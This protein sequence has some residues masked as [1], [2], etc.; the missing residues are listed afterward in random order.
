VV[1]LGSVAF[2]L[3]LGLLYRSHAIAKFDGRLPVKLV[4]DRGAAVTQIMSV[5]TTTGDLIPS[6]AIAGV[7]ALV[8]YQ[9]TRLWQ[10]WLLPLDIL[11]QIAIQ[12]AVINT[13][14]DYSVARVWPGITIG[15]TDGGVPSGSMARLLSVF[16]LTA[17]LWRPHNARIARRFTEIGLVVVLIELVTRMYLGRHFAGDIVAGL[18]L[19][20]TLT[21]AFGWVFTVLQRRTV[22]VVEDLAEGRHAQIR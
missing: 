9:R 13:M 17:I 20:V 12:A 8:F 1:L 16:L 6:F 7:F 2:L 3:L 22:V 21:V 15:G 14:K 19:G 4:H 11:V 18:S 10:A 5:A